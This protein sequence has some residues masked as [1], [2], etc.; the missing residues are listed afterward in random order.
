[1]ESAIAERAVGHKSLGK[2]V[3]RFSFGQTNVFWMYAPTL[4]KEL[5]DKLHTRPPPHCDD[6]FVA[7]LDWRLSAFRRGCSRIASPRPV[8]PKFIIYTDAC[9]SDKRQTGRIAA[10]PVRRQ[11]GA[12]VEV[13]SAPASPQLDRLFGDAN[14]LPIYGMGL[15]ELVATTAV[16]R[17]TLARAQV[18]AYF[19]NDP[20]SNGL[21]RGDAR[22]SIARNV[23]LRS[24]QLISDSP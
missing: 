24:R 21:V 23:I 17:R 7:N 19:D 4:A 8:S 1:M 5:Y 2:P 10:I 18:S 11:S 15:F 22:L 3:G 6:H 14:S 16:W 12:I 9:W 13:V 20:S